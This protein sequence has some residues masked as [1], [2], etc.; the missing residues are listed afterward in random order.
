MSQPDHPLVLIVDDH[1]EE[2]QPLKLALETTQKAKVVVVHP[3]DVQLKDLTEADL[4]LVD[5]MIDAWPD[6]DNISSISLK[7]PDGLA[8]ASVLRQHVQ[9]QSE[10]Q[11][12][13][14]FAILTGQ[15]EKLA[16]PLPSDLPPNILA[17]L[18]NLDWVFDK[19][20]VTNC[21]Q[22]IELAAAVGCLPPQWPQQGDKDSW[23]TLRRLLAVDPNPE[24][25]IHLTEDIEKCQ[26][27]IHELSK[28]SHGLAVVRWMSQ[29][30]LPYPCFLYDVQYL[31][32]R[33]RLDPRSLR[34]ALADGSP[35]RKSLSG[36]EYRGIL[37]Q[38]DGPRWWRSL[39]EFHLWNVSKGESANISHLRKMVCDAAGVPIK[40]SEPPENPVV[41]VD[42]HYRPL[43]FSSMS[44]AVRIQPDDWPVY[45]D[46]AWTTIEL[47]KSQSNLAGVVVSEHRE[48][49]E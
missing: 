11:S 7:P 17:R 42:R 23:Q 16:H 21:G 3:S 18:V 40:A 22:I 45:A 1:P 5:Y 44:E 39:V 29:R 43:K 20:V 9:K 48:R 26:P 49:I 6:R 41:C 47:A 33:L 13:T 36:F 8:L 38:F 31:A 2:A 27:P 25:M 34:E 4:V 35:L 15:M 19:G 32:A 46:P 10:K 37:S 28:W 30:I 14:A 12:P 24:N